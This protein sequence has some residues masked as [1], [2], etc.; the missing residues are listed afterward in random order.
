M[1]ETISKSELKKIIRDN[2]Q[3]LREAH[4]PDHGGKPNVHALWAS[5]FSS[6]RHGKKE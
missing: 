4:F 3:K 1:D 2:F 5:L 6:G